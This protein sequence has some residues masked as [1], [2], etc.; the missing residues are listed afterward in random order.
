VAYFFGLIEIAIQVYFTVHAYRRGK[1]NWMYFIIFVPVVG[2]GA[3]LFAEWLPEFERRM[4]RS[5]SGQSLD[6][7]ATD[8]SRLA[9]PT[10]RLEKLKEQLEFS[11][12]FENR[13]ALA[14]E[15]VDSGLYDEA[16]KLYESALT[17]VFKDDPGTMK[18]LAQAHFLS[19]DFEQA[20]Q[21]IEKIWDGHPDYRMIEVGIF[22]A[23]V[24]EKLGRDEDALAE[25]AELLKTAGGYEVR[26][27]Y[28]LLLK[29]NGQVEEAAQHFDHILTR[30]RQATRQYRRSQK[31]WIDIARQNLE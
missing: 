17:G 27:R 23:R 15:C 5:P 14:R 8:I 12:T 21:S 4:Q 6:N 2:S 9:N 24:L 29:K 11:D 16:I 13:I 28:A 18:E 31:Q 10:G 26:C 25:Y 30:A 3:Y 19:G 1:T 20:K 22:Y 7:I